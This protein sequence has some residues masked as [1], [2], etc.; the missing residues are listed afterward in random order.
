MLWCGMPKRSAGMWPLTRE[1]DMPAPESFGM[2]HPVS[3]ASTRP[4]S[5][6]L[7]PDC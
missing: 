2:P 7:T 4:T 5:R 1:E 6:L 3:A